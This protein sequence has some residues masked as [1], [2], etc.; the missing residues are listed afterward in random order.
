MN[1]I[2]IG[3]LRKALSHCG[4]KGHLVRPDLEEHDPILQHG[5]GGVVEGRRLA[6]DEARVDFDAVLAV[7]SANPFLAA[8]RQVATLPTATPN[9][10][11]NAGKT[12]E[13]PQQ[14]E[15]LT[16]N[17]PPLN[18]GGPDVDWRNRFGISWLTT[19]QNQGPCNSCWAFVAAA[20]IETM[21]RIEHCVWAKRSEGD[22]R[23]GMLAINNPNDTNVCAHGG[24]GMDVSLN[25]ATEHGVADY[26]CFPWLGP[27]DSSLTPLQTYKPSSD[28]SGRTVRLPTVTAVGDIEDQKRWLR[29]VGPLTA[30]FTVWSSFY[31]YS[32]GVYPND[33]WTKSDFDTTD[34]SSHDVLIVGYNDSIQCWIIRNSW[35]TGWGLEGY[36]YF[37]YGQIEIDT[38]TKFGYQG[39]NPDPWTK[40]RL[41]S[42]ALIETGDG[43]AHRNFSAMIPSMG[44][45]YAMWREGGENGDFSWHRGTPI[46]YAS[47]GG[48]PLSIGWP[49][50]IQTTYNRNLEIVYWS[51]RENAT[52]VHSYF[53]QTTQQWNDGGSF[54]PAGQVDGHPGFLQRNFEAPGRFEVVFR[55]SDGRL[56]HWQRL[57]GSPWTWSEVVR[58]G[59]NVL[60]SGP[61]LVQT[62]GGN[63][64]DMYVVCVLH[65]GAMQLFVWSPDR[66]ATPIGG[67]QPIVFEGNWRAADI[68]GSGIGDTPVCM[69]EG[70]FG[71]SDEATPGNLE[72]VV[73]VGGAIQ[74]W[75][76]G[77]VTQEWRQSATF[78]TDVAHVWGLVESSFGFNLEI[79]V[80]RTDS[81]PQHYWRDGLGW[82]AGPILDDTTLQP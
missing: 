58:F 22:V 29:D 44:S 50:A 55:T 26:G 4:L 36:G 40:R 28:R 20:L 2:T 18:F 33:V 78:G 80:Q 31:G 16:Y 56:A 53:D 19:I 70:Q 64:G 52:L 3:E 1:P 63:G 46:A 59:D 68:F 13:R 45:I 54:G 77:A 10:F 67:F 49:A 32:V 73:A 43:P 48:A 17:G 65:S 62:Q 11:S 35:G 12:P 5:T 6:K 79:L 82:H 25:W 66:Y 24:G 57:N 15:D 34:G 39:T 27:E 74:H 21:V 30:S 60:Q 76:R 75:W 47:G 81:L 72:L 37:G 23:D 14:R 51:L 42:G 61:A 8:A 7:Q 71:A 9:H 69:I 38:W 41:H